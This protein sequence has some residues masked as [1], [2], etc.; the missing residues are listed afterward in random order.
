MKKLTA[1][2]IEKAEE[3][4]FSASHLAGVGRL[5]PYNVICFHCQQAG[6]KWLKARLCEDSVVFP[7]THDL[8][9]LLQPLTE[10]YPDWNHLSRAAE[11]LTQPREQYPLSR[12]Q[13]YPRGYGAGF[14]GHGGCP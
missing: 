6:E 7:K 14:G 3:D 4:F 10:V 5:T 12:R 11:N 2:W 1:E 8:G 9:S 13:R